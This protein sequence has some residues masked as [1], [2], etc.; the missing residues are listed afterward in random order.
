MTMFT[1]R[2]I[3]RAGSTAV[4]PSVPLVRVASAKDFAPVKQVQIARFDC[5]RWNLFR[6][7]PRGAIG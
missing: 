7:L 3:L 2:G 4:S 5:E 1:R 6:D